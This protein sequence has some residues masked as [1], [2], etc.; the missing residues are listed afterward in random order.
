MPSD[1]DRPAPA[2]TCVVGLQ[3][4][5]EGKGKIVDLLARDA[6]VVARY[7]GGANAGHTLVVNGQKIVLHLVP[8]GIVHSNSVCLV[9][10]GVVVDPLQLEEEINTLRQLSVSCDGRLKVSERAHIVFS[11]HKL[12]DVLS[13]KRTRGKLGTTGRGIGP[14]YADKMTRVGI[15]AGDLFDTDTLPSLLAR[16]LELKNPLIADHFGERPVTVEQM[17]EECARFSAILRPFVCDTRQILGDAVRAGK[18]VLLEGAQGTM[19]DVDHGT[20]PFVT[21]SSSDALGVCAGTG[22]PPTAITDIVGVTKGYTT[23]V[24]EGPFPTELKDATGTALRE[25]GQ[26]YGATTGRPRRCGWLD[27]VAL[28]YAVQVN[29][30]TSIAITKIDV[31]DK[32][33]TVHVATRYRYEGIVMD[34]V[35]ALAGQLAKCQPVLTELPGWMASLRGLRKFSSL[36]ANA[37]A[38]LKFVED[39]VGV[40]VS[41]LSCGP[42]REDVIDLNE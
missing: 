3:W 16:N 6:D 42:G 34:R 28:K 17:Q 39:F 12:L 19:L 38:Y 29:G 2:T 26:E 22:L 5:D 11:I 8:S 37:R 18:R 4:G 10:N 14:C 30:V 41:I 40:P 36:P 7:Q 23:R 13:E 33:R 21:S 20:Y 24:G 15:R 35:P 31:L 9:S 32:L 1:V 25:E 27:L